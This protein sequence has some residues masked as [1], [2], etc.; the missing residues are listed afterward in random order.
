M[1]IG[2]REFDTARHTYVMG[3][4]NVTPD[5]FSDGGKYFGSDYTLN[6]GY[7]EKMREN[8][9]NTEWEKMEKKFFVRII[10]LMLIHIIYQGIIMSLLILYMNALMKC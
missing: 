6:S 8:L 10:S 3:I 5:S 2:C 1:K 7:A 9:S 4:L